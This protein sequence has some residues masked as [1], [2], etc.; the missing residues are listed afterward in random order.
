MT[1]SLTYASIVACTL[2]LAYGFAANGYT[3]PAIIIGF[4]GGSWI[5]ATLRGFLRVHGFAFA[6]FISLSVVGIWADISPWLALAGVIFSLIAWDLVTF[7]GRLGITDSKDDARK[8]ERAHLARLGLVVVISLLGY[9]ATTRLHIDLTFGAA[10]LLALLGVW[11][12]SA[13]VYSL[14]SH[15]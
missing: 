1:R 6:L 12:I 2:A 14:R 5:M 4:L 10:A 9:I 8:M 7:S 11:G 15:E 3:P 13:L